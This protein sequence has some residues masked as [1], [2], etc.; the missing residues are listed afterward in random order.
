MKLG[1]ANA[2]LTKEQ[3]A[4]EME[5]R[6]FLSNP[7]IVSAYGGRASQTLSQYEDWAVFITEAG[8]CTV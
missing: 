1:E 8:F 5:R 4:I 6:K 7:L 2:A 3:R